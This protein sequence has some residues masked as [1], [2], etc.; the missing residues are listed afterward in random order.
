ME[1]H[2]S[3]WDL[4]RIASHFGRSAKAIEARIKVITRLSRTD[5]RSS[6]TG[7]RWSEAD[8]E[9][10][11]HLANDL[12]LPL[13]EIADKL[14]RTVIACHK[15]FQDMKVS[16]EIAETPK[17]KADDASGILEAPFSSG[18]KVKS[19]TGAIENELTLELSKRMD[20]TFVYNV[21]RKTD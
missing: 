5:A 20:G 1:L 21:I 3:S 9:K 10:L 12:D 2:Q 4:D 6:H 15:R 14:E 8:N 16:K 19:T 13:T 7:K 11:W 18:K 17:R